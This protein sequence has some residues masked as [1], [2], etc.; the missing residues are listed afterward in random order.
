SR[1][2]LETLRAGGEPVAG[3]V[4]LRRAAPDEA[5]HGEG[6]GRVPALRAMRGKMP[7]GG[8]GY[9]EVRTGDSVRLCP[10]GSRKPEAG[11]GRRWRS[12]TKPKSAPP[13]SVLPA[14]GVN[15]FSFK[16][17][18]VN[19]TGSASANSL[20]MQSIFRMGIPV[21][22]KNIFPSNIQGFPT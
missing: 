15:D 11:S 19:G 4:R 1:S 17:A 21:S 3:R 22:G 20:L 2:P 10:A 7:D 9:E 8:V 14:F 6:R 18:T 16:I 12:M 5:R 13:A